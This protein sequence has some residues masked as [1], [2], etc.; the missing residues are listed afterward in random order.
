VKNLTSINTNSE[1]YKPSIVEPFSEEEIARRARKAG[2]Q[3]SPFTADTDLDVNEKE[4]TAFFRNL[5]DE[6]RAKLNNN[7]SEIRRQKDALI[8]K[9]STNGDINNV[10]QKENDIEPKVMS[11]EAINQEKIKKLSN[12]VGDALRRFRYYQSEQSLEAIEPKKESALK[13]WSILVTLILVEWLALSFFYGQTSNYGLAGGFMTAGIV[14]L[15]IAVF[16]W[17]LGNSIKKFA[18]KSSVE[19]YTNMF[20]AFALGSFLITSILFSGHLR[21]AAS[22][23]TQQSVLGNSVE[24]AGIGQNEKQTILA[25][26]EIDETF[27]ASQL[28]WENILIHGAFV[29]DVLSWLLMFASAAFSLLLIKK[30]HSYLGSENHY[31]NLYEA[32]KNKEQELDG[33]KAAYVKEVDG[34]Y[35]SHASEIKSITDKA[36]VRMT[37][38]QRMWDEYYAQL[39]RFEHYVAEVEG[40]CNRSLSKYRS[41]NR[42]IATDPAPKHFE[43]AFSIPEVKAVKDIHSAEYTQTGIDLIKPKIVSLATFAKKVIDQIEKKREMKIE[44]IS[45]SIYTQL[46]AA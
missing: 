8:S 44:A 22:L 13:H 10:A 42:S 36:E 33:A 3:N 39:N 11:V 38:L 28:A 23:I 29:A 7:L 43:S 4:I 25:S 35:S 26:P 5:V 27:L 6:E 2:L 45:S 34:V 18:S 37:E 16:S 32:W 20:I 19:K 1:K 21:Y 30:T 9:A 12:E 24:L 17:M 31:W 14:G 15:P 46:K 41:I 40:A